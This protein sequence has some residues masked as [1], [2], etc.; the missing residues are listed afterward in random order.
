MLLSERSSEMHDV[1]VVPTFSDFL[2]VNTVEMTSSVTDG[3]ETLHTRSEGGIFYF[4]DMTTICLTILSQM[5]PCQYVRLK[6]P[7]DKHLKSPAAIHFLLIFLGM[8]TTMKR[9]MKPR[10]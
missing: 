2:R 4:Y 8:A 10:S 9:R 1:Q 5:K 7:V 6:T 3:T